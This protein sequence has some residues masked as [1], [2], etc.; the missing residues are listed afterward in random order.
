VREKVSYDDGFWQEEDLFKA[1]RIA[2]LWRERECTL[3]GLVCSLTAFSC[4]S[5]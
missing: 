4:A 1:A 5:F 3:G 2:W